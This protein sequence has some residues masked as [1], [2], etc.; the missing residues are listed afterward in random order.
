MPEPRPPS[1]LPPADATPRRARKPAVR[2]NELPDTYPT[3]Q[4]VGPSPQEIALAPVEVPFAEAVPV[5]E[6]V[7]AAGYPEAPALVFE[8][9]PALPRAA[10]NPLRTPSRLPRRLLWMFATAVVAATTFVG[11][12]MIGDHRATRR[13]EAAN[14]KTDSPAAAAAI[15]KSDAPTADPKKTAAVRPATTKPTD[16]PK[17]SDPPR[18]ANPVMSA[19]SS[20]FETQVLPILQAKCVVCHG[21]RAKKGELDVRTVAGL[22]KGGE[23]GAAVVP[24]DLNTSVLWEF[25]SNNKMP[26]GKSGKLTAAEKKTIQDWI[27]GGAK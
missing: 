2:V 21:G 10:L 16:A 25:I 14:N 12:M 7:A 15:A 3:A 8:A 24:G 22:K 23:N 4:G 17:K 6:P 27:V 18:P 19:T 13:F 20:A 26:P 5:A 1:K 9:I 11:G